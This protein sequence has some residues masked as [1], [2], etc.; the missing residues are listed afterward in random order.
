LSIQ[1]RKR[2]NKKK[3]RGS[4]NGKFKKGGFLIAEGGKK[5]AD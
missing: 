3:N 1:D 5:K 4:G 2:A